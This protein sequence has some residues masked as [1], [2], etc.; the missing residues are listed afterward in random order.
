[1]DVAPATPGSALVSARKFVEHLERSNRLRIGT[2]YFIAVNTKGRHS[3]EPT[4]K[5]FGHYL[6]MEAIGHGVAWTD[7]HPD[8]N[9]KIPHWGYNWYQGDPL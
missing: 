2:L 3:K 9:I 5:D 7:D 1:M 6:A 4:A 8:P